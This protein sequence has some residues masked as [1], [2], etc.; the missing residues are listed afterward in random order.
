MGNSENHLELTLT[1]QAKYCLLV[2]NRKVGQP[3]YRGLSSTNGSFSLKCPNINKTFLTKKCL[4]IKWFTW[5][6]GQLF[7]FFIC[8]NFSKVCSRQIWGTAARCPSHDLVWSRLPN[9]KASLGNLHGHNF[10]PTKSWLKHVLCFW[11]T[12]YL[13]HARKP[14][15]CFVNEGE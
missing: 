2:G 1:I 4:L 3:F 11:S 12:R 8:L 10:F 9:N 14:F 13:V 7:L 6:W 15:I 5:D